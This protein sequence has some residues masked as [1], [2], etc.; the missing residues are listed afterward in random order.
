ML[1]LLGVAS[2]ES[3]MSFSVR[4]DRSGLEYQ[5]GTFSACLPSGGICFDRRS[6]A[7]CAT[8]CGSIARHRVC[9]IAKTI[10]R[11]WK[12]TSK[13]HRYSPQF[14]EHYLAPMGASIWSTPPGKFRQFPAR[15]TVGFFHNHGL[16]Q[17]RDRPQWKTIVGGAVKIRG[18]TPAAV[19]R[20]SAAELPCRPGGATRGPRC[21]NT[22]G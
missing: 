2:R 6:T 20:S 12:T 9:S 11:R 18:G 16:L 22:S 14:V 10:I 13:Q 5:G 21:D 15:H 19:G 7:C 3:E 17:L 1:D 8:S 4:C